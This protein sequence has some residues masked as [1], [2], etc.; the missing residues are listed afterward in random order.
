MRISIPFLLIVILHGP[1]FFFVLLPY[2]SQLCLYHVA[3][4]STEFRREQSVAGRSLGGPEWVG[5][6]HLR[7]ADRIDDLLRRF[8][9]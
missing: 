2:K 4:V 3:L 8:T 1:V 9:F 5:A 7:E 6:S